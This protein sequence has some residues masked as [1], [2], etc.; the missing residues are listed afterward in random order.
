ML[1]RSGYVWVDELTDIA[2]N[3]VNAQKHN[4][5]KFLNDDNIDLTKTEAQIMEEHGFVRVY[6]SGVIT[7]QWNKPMK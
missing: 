4:L 6:D 5:K 1:F 3:R 2:Y 7:W